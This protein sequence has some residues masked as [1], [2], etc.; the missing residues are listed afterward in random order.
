MKKLFCSFTGL[1]NLLHSGKVSF[2]DLQSND[3]LFFFGCAREH[4]FGDLPSLQEI[5]ARWTSEKEFSCYEWFVFRP[6]KLLERNYLWVKEFRKILLRA[7]NEG[8]VS[9]KEMYPCPLCKEPYY[10]NKEA[11]FFLGRFGFWL[12]EYEEL[13]PGTWNNYPAME[14]ALAGKV[15]VLWR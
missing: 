11:Q 14:E 6:K 12:P 9:W 3:S 4:V 10:R 1:Y 5:E 13:S 8:R 2:E 7:E 15:D